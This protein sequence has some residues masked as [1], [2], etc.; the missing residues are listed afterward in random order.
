MTG[1]ILITGANGYLGAN[2][3]ERYA[4]TADTEVVAVWHTGSHRQ[5]A[6]APRHV[7][8]ASCDLTDAA[9]VDALFRRT[10]IDKVLHAAALL[11]DGRPDYLRRAVQANIA[12]TANL[13]DAATAAGCARFVY[14]SSI[15]VYG[16]GPCP[17]GGWDETA[18]VA[19]ESIYGWTKHAGEES[20]RLRCA[21]GGLTGVSLRFAGIHGRGR[22]S[23]VAY[24]MARA[25]LAGQP[26]VVNN[27]SQ[28]FQL[29]FV[30]DAV[31]AAVSALEK[32]IPQPFHCI[33]IASHVFPSLQLMAEC[34]T[35]AFHSRSTIQAG[36]NVPGG[37][38]VM[39][40]TRMVTTIGCA[41]TEIEPHLHRIGQMLREDVNRYAQS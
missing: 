27:P 33:N 9:H 10:S 24:H 36:A 5:I 6:D 25:A 29:L 34:I 1:C 4:A 15:S 31:A 38:Q 35:R 19:P 40:T 14:C 13:V 20:V 37:D 2:C 12:A 39:N 21:P 28:R 32:P 41:G 18:P 23:G 22:R 26:L 7:R 11:P 3:V 8:Y 17:E 16:A 30:D